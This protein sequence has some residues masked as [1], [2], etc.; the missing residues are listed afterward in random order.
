VRTISVDTAAAV[1][2]ARDSGGLFTSMTDLVQRAALSTEQVEALATAGAFDSLG[3]TRRGALWSA[4]PVSAIRPEH[5]PLPT[6]DEAAPPPLP[7]MTGP[8]QLIA[9]Y[10]A[11]SIT[12]DTYP[13]ALIRDRLDE[14]G[15]ICAIDLRLVPDRT[16]VLVGGVVTHRQRPNTAQGIIFL[17]LED[18]TGMVNVVCHPAV[19][20]R[21]R[22]VARESGGLLIR[23][24]LERVEGVTNVIAE[25]IEKLNLGIRTGSR[26]FR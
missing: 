6:V 12:K 4:A 21:N 26:D 18:E 11:T 14:L 19:W 17:N 20:N 15:V 22:R 7:E 13:T 5:L 10:W 25:K 23:G 9:D 24:M 16:R 8:E 1:I 3:R 2:T